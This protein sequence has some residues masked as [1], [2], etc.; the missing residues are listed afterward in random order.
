MSLFKVASRDLGNLPLL[1]RLAATGKPLVLS[2]GMSTL[3]EIDEA[4]TVVRRH[5]EQVVLLH[6]TSAYPTP[7]D[8]VNLRALPRLRAEFG[9]HVG[10]SDHSI[11]TVIAPAAIALGA[12]LIRSMAPAPLPEIGPEQRGS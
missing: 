7:D 6:C 9:V 4:L 1:E 3:A 5:H 12:V 10:L 2:C 11:G 8:Q